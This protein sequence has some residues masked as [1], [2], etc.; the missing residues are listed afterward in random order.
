[1]NNPLIQSRPEIM[2]GKPVIAGTRITVELILEKL[3]AGETIEQLLRRISPFDQARRI[4]RLG[5]CRAS[6]ESGRD[7]SDFRTSRM[8]VLADESVE[9]QIV[10]RLRQDDIR[11]FMLPK[12]NPAS[13][14]ILSCGARMNSIMLIT[15]DKD[16]GELVFRQGLAHCGVVLV[17]WRDCRRTPKPSWSLKR[18]P[19]IGPSYRMPSV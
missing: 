11:C 6:L 14:I 13:R 5:L 9:R 1:M 15:E 17:R 4:S 16:F 19:R 7:L 3:A 18:L 8:N 2:M 10:A 12:W